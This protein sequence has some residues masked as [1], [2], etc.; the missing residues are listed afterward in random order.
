MLD[1][2]LHTYIYPSFVCQ[3]SEGWVRH[4]GIG[5]YIWE[6][7]FIYVLGK[8]AFVLYRD[9]GK[10][11]LKQQTTGLIANNLSPALNTKSTKE[12]AKPHEEI[13]VLLDDTLKAPQLGYTLQPDIIKG[14]HNTYVLTYIKDSD[15]TVVQFKVRDVAGNRKLKIDNIVDSR[16]I[17]QPPAPI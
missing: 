17:D 5:R 3:P 7:A 14:P 2:F 15:G 9:A 10:N 16:I 1:F 6:I 12:P 11:A 4:C 8:L 13:V